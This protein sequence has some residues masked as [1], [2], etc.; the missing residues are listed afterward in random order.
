MITVL[1]LA[2]ANIKQK[3]FRSVLI[4][5]SIILSVA[6]MYAVLSMSSSTQ[7]IFEH[8]I[9]KETGSAEYILLPEETSEKPYLPELDFIEVK[10]KEYAIPLVLAY[11]YSEIEDDKIPIAFTGISVNDYKTV[12]GLEYIE[13]TSEEL[14]GR[15]VLIGEQTATEYGLKLDE[16]L[17]VTI[18]GEK[19]TFHITG[20]VEDKNNNLG[21]DL[22]RLELVANRNTLSDILGI[23]NEVSAYYTKH[24]T[25]SDKASFFRELTAAYPDYTIK[26]VSDLDFIKQ[27]LGMIT[28]SLFLMVSAVIMVS[29]FIIYSSFKMIAIERMPLMGTLRSIGATR[30]MTV[31][32]LLWEGVIYGVLGGVLG[33]A[34]GTVI[35]SICMK[36][37][38]ANF[39]V[40]T[41][42]ISYINIEYI[43]IAF[44]IGLVL[45]TGSALLPI[46]KTSKRSIRSII[47]AE[48]INEKH[49]SNVKTILGFLLIL[50]GFGL[51]L[52]APLKVEL[53]LTIIGMALVTIGGAFIIPKLSMLLAYLLALVL[54]PIYKDALGVTMVNLKNDRTMMNN[55]MLLAMGL[56]VI[57]MINNFSTTVGSAVT[58]VYASGKMDAVIFNNMNSNFIEDVSQIEDVAHV[59]TTK[60]FQDV[61]ANN[62]VIHLMYLEGIDGDGYS[63]YAWNEFG[64]YLTED[65]VKEFRS[66]RTA[67]ITQFVA[68]KYELTRGD[69][70]K[71]D[72]NGSLIDY[73]ILEIVPS[74]MNNGNVTYVYEGFLAEDAGIENVQSMFLDFKDGAD[75]KKVIQEIKELMPYDILSIQTLEEMRDLNMQQNNGIFFLMKAISIIS[76]FIGIVGVF[77][78][79]TISFLS[80]KKVIATMRSLGLSKKKTLSNILVEAFLCG[81]LGTLSGLVLGTILIKSMY[82]VAN[83]MGLPGDVMYYSPKDF[84]FVLGSGIVLSLLSAVLPAISISKENIVSG[85]R[86]E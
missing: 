79:F 12:Y 77:N 62:G 86:Y 19:Y 42:T 1:K 71:M 14:V 58:D 75:W 47:F 45:A 21:Y 78:N 24:L 65:I 80:R 3:K 51:F 52:F 66:R 34:L 55:I 13:Q 41:E 73:E 44:I 39:G 18:A 11:G 16:E 43:I 48:I 22:G 29:A 56:G 50:T 6:L 59:Y 2:M 83:A 25:G 70:L 32:I 82:Y 35:L 26:D 64:D 60:S 17:I 57:L 10:E 81:C 84:I 15:N 30:I 38:L 27:M 4:I 33:N 5:L 36:M 9:R 37:M 28:T 67:I 7:K 74:I 69:V 61:K 40:S 53:I 23:Q 20:V 46:M 63:E 76:M 49:L 85:L 31:R 68:R 72:L 8:K 54:K